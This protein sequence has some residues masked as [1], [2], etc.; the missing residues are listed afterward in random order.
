MAYW[1][2]HDEPAYWRDVTRHFPPDAAIVDL[3]CGTGWLGDHVA[4]Y[5]GVERSPEAVEAGLARG[6]NLVLADLEDPP[7]PFPDASFDGAVL[8]DVLEH[9]HD[10]AAVVGEARRLLRP[11]GLVFASSPDAQRWVWDD[12]THVRPFTGR[13]YRKLFADQGFEVVRTGYESVMPGIGRLS[14]LTGRHARPPLL[15]ALART[16][17]VRR[18]VWLLARAPHAPSAPS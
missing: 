3:G 7:L 4:S 5:T 15:N 2:W 9:V 18:N 14:A 1:D 12:Y 17:L 13:A 16:R 6:R 8:K 11:D 10:P